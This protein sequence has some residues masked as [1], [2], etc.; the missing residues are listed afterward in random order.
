MTILGRRCLNSIGPEVLP[1]FAILS[2][3]TFVRFC[4][5]KRRSSSFFWL[6]PALFF[7]SSF[8]LTSC[9]QNFYFA[10]RTLP[11]SR[12]TNRVLIAEQ[13]PSIASKGALPFVDAYYDIRHAYNNSAVTFSISG[14]SGALP[15]TIQNMPEQQVGAVYGA[16]DGSYAVANYITESTGTPISIPGGLSS[17]VFVTQS[18]DFVYATNQRS[19]VI[20][21]VN[22]AGGKSYVLN[23]PNAYRVSI[24]PGG[25]VALVFVENSTQAASTSSCIVANGGSTSATCTPPAGQFSVYSIVRLTNDQ[26]NAAINNPNYA[27]AQDCEPQ[28]LPQFCV[29]PVS[30]GASA[31]FDHPLK[32]LF[33]PD[34][35]TAY[36]LNCGVECGGT[37]S[38]LTTIPITASALNPGVTGASGIALT[39]QNTYAVPAGV[40][41]GVFSGNLLYLAGQQL[42]SDGLFAGNLSIFNTETNAVTSTYSISDG[43]H[44]RMVFADGSTLWIGS[45]QCQTGERYKQVQAGSGG[46]YGCLTMFNTSTAAVTLDSYKGDATGIAAVTGLNK[47]YTAEGGQIYIYNTADMSQRDNSNVSVAGTAVD[48]A[49][50]DATSDSDNT[51]Y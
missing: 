49:Y 37:A 12:L 11:P 24:N 6:L 8:L 15:L 36:V 3:P 38:S 31:T 22:V 27:G 47:V 42:Q 9:G 30:T 2:L 51:S 50:M 44:N 34:G 13:T 41:N 32:A 25:S 33:S 16:G 45:T 46:Q 40:T 20:S 29:F 19:H 7:A 5:L 26:S 1:R 35:S 48:V 39:A 10:G 23:L 14:Y 43:N 18:R 17:S 4:I 21:V 28:N